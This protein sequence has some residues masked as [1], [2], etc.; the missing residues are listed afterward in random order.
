MRYLPLYHLILLIAFWGVQTNNSNAQCSRV[1]WVASVTPGCGAKIIDLD[2]GDILQAFSGSEGLTG[3]QTITFQ[4]GYSPVPLGCTVANALPVSLTCVS[5]TLPCIAHYGYYMHADNPLQFTFTANIYDAS[6]QTCE[7]EFG[8]G[9][10]AV[11]EQVT[12]GFPLQGAYQVCLRV[13]DPFG[14]VATYCETVV[15]D[16]EGANGCG[17]E[18]VVTAVGTQ[19]HGKLIPAQGVNA[20]PLQS[21]VWYSSKSSNVL[22]Q[23]ESFTAP[24]PGYG[25]YMVCAQYNVSSPDG[26]STCASTQCRELIIAE[27]GCVN[28]VMSDVTAI[29]PSQSALYVPV[30]GCNGVTYGNECEAITSGVFSWMAGECSVQS[31][32]CAAQMKVEIVEGSLDDGFVAQFINQSSNDYTYA[33]IDFGDGNGFWEGTSWDTIYHPYPAGGIYRTNLTNWKTGGCVSSVVQ[34]LVTD[35][36]HMTVADLPAGTDYVRPGDANKDGKANAYDLLPLGIGHNSNGSPRPDATTE[37]TMQ[38]APNWTESVAGALNY[39]H[40]DCNGNGQVNEYDADVIGLHYVPLDTTPVV[41]PSNAPPL[42]VVFQQDTLVVNASVPAPVEIKGKVVLGSAAQPALGLYGLAFS[43]LYPDFVSHNPLAEYKT[44]YFGSPNHMLWLDHDT[45]ARRQLDIAVTRKNGLNAAGY[46][47]IADVTF[48]ADFIIIIDVADRS[49]NRTIPFTV[50]IRGIRA[51][52]NQGQLK[53]IGTPATLDT[54]WIKMIGLTNTQDVLAQR[55]TVTPN[56]ST[57]WATLF[58]GDLNTE[59]VEVFDGLGRNVTFLQVN[60]ENSISLNVQDLSPGVYTL[61]VLTTDGAV[62]KQLVVE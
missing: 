11:G 39:K 56:P 60:G 18:M 13:S 53:Q 24:L 8:D 30:C 4:T 31:A 51:N 25:R 14:S 3:G 2:N 43:M 61:R 21:V 7:W 9:S 34:L 5:D 36:L 38:F 55:I 50:P 17:Y 22:A 32:A 47:V 58:F 27:P 59:A 44:D 48:R 29:C 20:Y 16:A 28:P 57:Q 35:A 42:R 12:H 23:T 62:L 40:L 46:G 33:Q 6:S 41:A 26:L 37:W 1:G 45:H 15:V 54:I 49:S 10:V 52:D 19:L